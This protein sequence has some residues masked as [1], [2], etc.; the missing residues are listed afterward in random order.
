[1]L[2]LK[3]FMLVAVLRLLGSLFQ[4][5]GPMYDRLCIP[6][7]DLR[8]ANFNFLLQQLMATHSHQ[9]DRKLHCPHVNCVYILCT[10]IVQDVCNWCIQN[11]YHISTSFCIHFV[12]KIK[13]TMPAKFCI[14]FVYKS[15]SKCGIHFVYKHFVYILHTSVLIYRK[16]TS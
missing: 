4:V 14:H 9:Q 16:C 12:Y 3:Q 15:L 1:M 6:N 11:V 10:K 13:R 8:K 2:C 5:L 7:F